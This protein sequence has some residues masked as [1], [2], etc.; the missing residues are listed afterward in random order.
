M[1]T[2]LEPVVDGRV[3]A[4]LPPSLYSHNDQLRAAHTVMGADTTGHGVLARIAEVL[5]TQASDG[6]SDDSGGGSDGGGGALDASG[7]GLT[8][9]HEQQTNAKAH[10]VQGGLSLD[11]GLTVTPTLRLIQTS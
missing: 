3:D 7:V 8:H 5:R 10:G 4:K 9:K 2:L 6:G 1:G 11:G